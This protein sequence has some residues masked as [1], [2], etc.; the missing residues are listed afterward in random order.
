MGSKCVFC[1]KY[2]HLKALKDLPDNRKPMQSCNCCLEAFEMS[3]MFFSKKVY[4]SVLNC[5]W[6]DS[7]TFLEN[8]LR[9][10]GQI[11][12]SRSS[13]D[14]GIEVHRNVFDQCNT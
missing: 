11:W 14:I 8:V 13:T 7:M 10:Y 9:N 4:V 6:G 3:V 12:S 1:Y 5:L 2:S